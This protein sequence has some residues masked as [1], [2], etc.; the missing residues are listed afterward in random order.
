ML[1]LVASK[2]GELVT[3]EVVLVHKLIVQPRVK[4]FPGYKVKTAVCTKGLV[5][6]DGTRKNGADAVG[7]I[8]WHRCRFAPFSGFPPLVDWN[9]RVD[10]PT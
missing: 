2:L 10:E 9:E 3:W 8:Q 6:T 1:R 7:R 4:I 5:A